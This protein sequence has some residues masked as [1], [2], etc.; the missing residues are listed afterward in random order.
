MKA[1]LTVALYFT[2][3]AMLML[4]TAYGTAREIVWADRV[5]DSE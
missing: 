2:F 5:G 4:A 1:I 3:V